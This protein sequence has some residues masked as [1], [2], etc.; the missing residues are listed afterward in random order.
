VVST[1]EIVAQACPL[2]SELGGLFYFS[3]QALT[4]GASLGLDPV[5]LYFLG[6]GGVLGD[7]EATVIN[8]TFGYFKESAVGPIWNS[9]RALVDP[10]DA[11]RAYT[12]CCQEFGRHHLADVEGLEAFCR[13][14][15]AVAKAAP[16]TAL[17][18][19]AGLAQQ[20]LATDFPALATQLIT[21]LR[22][23][24]GGSHL[25]AITSNGLH[26]TVAHYLS[27]PDVFFN[28]GYEEKD[29][30]QVTDDDRDRLRAANEL[31]DRLMIP[32]FSVL[33]PSGEEIL[34]RGLHAIGA[35]LPVPS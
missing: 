5:Q 28:F 23:F 7:V 22:E 17:P 9:A 32:A 33:E 27:R 10:R 15:R 26:P 8:C 25:L 35:R 3:E 12:E 13:E 6:R 34:L 30:P 24:R 19:F 4:V 29:V 21:L 1:E 31:T 11:A 18:L 20:P 14:A 16:T 2:I